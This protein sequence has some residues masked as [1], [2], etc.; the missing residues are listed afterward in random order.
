MLVFQGTVSPPDAAQTLEQAV[1]GL[2]HP[3]QSQPWKKQMN[4]LSSTIF[5][6]SGCMED[7]YFMAEVK[8]IV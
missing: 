2:R 8:F 4:L 1:Q 5:F 7:I 6:I 3:C